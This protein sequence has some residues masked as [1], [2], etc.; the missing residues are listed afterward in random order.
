MR[1]IDKSAVARRCAGALLS[2]ALVGAAFVTYRYAPEQKFSVTADQP[3]PTVTATELATTQRPPVRP[4]PTSK[5][6]PTSKGKL[7]GHTAIGVHLVAT[8][9]AD[10]T[11]EVSE[12]AIF[13]T[14]RSDVLLS[15]PKASQGGAP[16][17]SAV[18]VAEDV[19]LSAAG[20]P[21][22]VGVDGRLTRAE[23]VRLPAAVSQLELRYRLSGSTVRSIPSVTGRALALLSPL[24]AV[25]DQ[26]LPVA[27]T[28]RGPSVRNLICPLLAPAKRQCAPTTGPPGVLPRMVA[29]NA[30]V[31]A[32]LDLPKPT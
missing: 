12:T 27:I 18:P 31:V 22:A 19:Q 21:V 28:I 16:L 2:S 6:L 5:V 17:R 9:R 15:P 11:F 14:P 29:R 20:Q 10:G 32:Q 8:P 25:A 7:P 26:A 30:V 13:A 3:R 4:A 1:T 23:T 24:T